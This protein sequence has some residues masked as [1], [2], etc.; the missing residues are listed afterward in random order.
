MSV[1][2]QEL[3]GEGKGRSRP[4]R[5]GMTRSRVPSA[6]RPMTGYISVRFD[7]HQPHGSSSRV[8][9]LEL[10]EQLGQKS[11]S[12]S[13]QS[14]QMEKLR[15]LREARKGEDI[16]TSITSRQIFPTSMPHKRCIVPF[17]LTC[18]FHLSSSWSITDEDKF[19]SRSR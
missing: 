1:C 17:R 16:G 5:F 6:S 10:P 12:Q 7:A 13:A 15:Y 18:R 19:R 9:K 14:S 4:V 11:T 2:G 3:L 8:R